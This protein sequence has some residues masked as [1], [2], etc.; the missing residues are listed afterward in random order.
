MHGL[1]ADG[2]DFEPIVPHLQLPEASAVRFV[3]P[4]APVRPVT[5]NGGM[6]MRAWYDIRAMA[7]DRSPDEAGIRESETQITELV[8]REV[9]RGVDPQRVVLAG[10]SQGGAM[11]LQVGL[12][13]PSPPAGVLALSC[14]LLLPEELADERSPASSGLPILMVH[15]T[16]DPVVPLALGRASRDRL[17]ALGFRPDWREYAMGHEV[18]MEEIH[19]AG[20][21]MRKV[22]AL[23]PS[24]D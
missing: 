23:S 8:D 5:V 24:M 20:S 14:Y 17:D 3:F 15:G 7:I 13:L 10:F 19:L 12:R 11:A 6:V 2:H 1:G 21:W 22:L 18:C 9:A 16:N 4:H